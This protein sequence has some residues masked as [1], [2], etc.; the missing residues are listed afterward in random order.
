[1]NPGESHGCPLCLTENSIT[2]H[3]SNEGGKNLFHCSCS[4]CGF[5]QTV[6]ENG[7]SIVVPWEIIRIQLMESADAFE[8]D[9]DFGSDFHQI[10][11]SFRVAEKGI[12]ELEKLANAPTFR[13]GED[14]G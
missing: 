4:S 5:M 10:A 12:E 7:I 8:R 1:M 11:K 3:Q 2:L 9:D 14:C 13:T 6:R